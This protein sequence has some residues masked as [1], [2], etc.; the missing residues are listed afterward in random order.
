VDDLL[1]LAIAIG[2]FALAAFI[3]VRGASEP[4]RRP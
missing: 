2:L 4:E 1:Y 3:A